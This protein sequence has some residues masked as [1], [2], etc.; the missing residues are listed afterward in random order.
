MAVHLSMEDYHG[1][2]ASG[3]VD[4][5]TIRGHVCRGDEAEDETLA[6]RGQSSFFAGARKIPRVSHRA[7]PIKP[8]PRPLLC[9]SL[10]SWH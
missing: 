7:S 10:L 4:A 9:R 2:N 1:V 6:Q 5:G 3:M 8:P